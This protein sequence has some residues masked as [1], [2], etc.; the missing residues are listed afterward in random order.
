M[1]QTSFRLRALA[2]AVA[3]AVV[4][5]GVAV[6]PRGP[7]LST[8]VAGDPDLV[9]ASRPMLESA[10]A[11]RT[12]SVVVV[13]GDSVSTAHFGA[14]DDT[15][16]EI[17]SVSKTFT[18]AL[19]AD[20]IERGDVSADDEV[21]EYLDLEGAPIAEVSLAELAQHTSGLPSVPGGFGA[22]LAN[23]RSVAFGTDPYGYDFDELLDHARSESLGGRGDYS[24]SNMGISLLGH[25]VAVASTPGLATTDYPDA[26]AMLLQARILGPL[27]MTQTTVPQRADDL[28]ADA[29]TGLTAGGRHSD[30]WTLGSYAPSGSIR[31]T[32]RD[33]A[34]WASALL[35]GS[36]PGSAA[37][38]PSSTVDDALEVGYA[39]HVSTEPGAAAEP[40]R[41]VTWHNGRTG[42]FASML[43][44]DREAGRAAFVV[45]DSATNVDAAGVDLLD[46]EL[47]G[48]AAS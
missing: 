24:Y 12:A 29:P 48:E 39:W 10:G 8:D 37:L 46:A 47:V 5:L 16:Y 2:I 1:P 34:I 3:V 17:G 26:Y 23:Y 43:A 11:L 44:L 20:A 15:V 27:G 25:A 7:A 14:A 21:G 42:G 38:D 28:P 4:A 6:V 32:P 36:A 40:D 18:A 9:Q 45:V 41:V 22:I 35:D 19:F 31:S 13:D 33:M 30:A